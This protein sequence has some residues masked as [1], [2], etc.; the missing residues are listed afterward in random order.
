MA[1]FKTPAGKEIDASYIRNLYNEVKV[2]RQPYYQRWINYYKQ[3]RSYRE[4]AN[5]PFRSSLFIPYTFSL[6]EHVVPS[7]LSSIFSSEPVISVSPRKGAVAELATLIEE[8]LNYFIED[9]RLKLY[10]RLEDFFKEAAIYGTSFARILPSFTKENFYNPITEEF[11]PF[12]DYVKVEPIDLFRVY[13]DWRASDIDDMRF[14]IIEHEKSED[15]L[16]ELAALG[17]IEKGIIDE[18]ASTGEIDRAKAERLGEV[19]LSHTTTGRERKF[20]KVLEYWDRN[21]VIWVCE[22]RIIKEVENVLG[23]FPFVM[24][25]YTRVP[26]ELY[27]IGI[28]EM[29]ADLQEELNTIR[30]Q[31]IDNLNLIINRMFIVNKLA[32]ID[33]DSLVSYAGNCILTNDVDAIRPLDTRDTVRSSYLEEDIIKADIEETTGI[34][35]YT[36]GL[37][38]TRREPAT[39]TIRLQQAAFVRFDAIMKMMEYGVIREIASIFLSYI[40]KYLPP[41]KFA[42]IV[43]YNEFI[44][45]GGPLFYMIPLNDILKNYHF[46]PVG[47]AITGVRELRTQQLLNAFAMFAKFPFTNV[48]EFAKLVLREGFGIKN[49]EQLLLPPQSAGGPPGQPQPEAQP[50]EAGQPQE[51]VGAQGQSPTQLPGQALEPVALEELATRGSENEGVNTES[52]LRGLAGI[53]TSVEGR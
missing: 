45:R 39:T 36:R 40:R 6:V 19:G 35:R 27:G 48:Y 51:M 10:F 44:E 38:P 26:H 24:M 32:D 25:Q 53:V 28:P 9:N 5:Y 13:P 17:L 34:T 46:R 42:E 49:I 14:I 16:Y 20:F 41:E 37:P 47:S 3:Y 30:N 50:T 8:V 52:L 15:E 43:G 33:M 12:L 7:T 29:I 23:V 4:E 21:C 1:K 31:R 2:W 22:D 18:L 11:A